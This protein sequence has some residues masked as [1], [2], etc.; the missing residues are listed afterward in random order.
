MVLDKDTINNIS[1][2]VS[3]NYRLQKLTLSWSQLKSIDLM[4][5]MRNIKNI[6]HL[7]YLDISAIPFE[8]PKS[9][10]LT[11]LFKNHIVFNTSLIHLDMSC[12]NLSES[13]Y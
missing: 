3:N 1:N 7:K 4:L 2:F 10:E 13:I 8:G 5:L 9:L 11:Q 6:K 12:C